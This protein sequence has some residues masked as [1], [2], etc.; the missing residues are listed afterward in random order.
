[1]ATKE[2]TDESS[3][4]RI[5]VDSQGLV[6]ILVAVVLAAALISYDRLD[7]GVNTTEPNTAIR[8]WMG[9]FGARVV[10]ELHL[11]LGFGIWVLPVLLLGFGCAS[12][13]PS[14][15]Y[16]RR[17]RSLFASVGLV[18]ACV[19]VLDLCERW[20]PGIQLRK[21]SVPSPGGFIGHQNNNARVEY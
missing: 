21:N 2:R 7:L 6:L 11:V 9:R 15:A 8:N 18:I 16:L 5:W 17:W 3:R 12:F 1:M 19:G 14:L 10:Y 13:V 4:D 20:I